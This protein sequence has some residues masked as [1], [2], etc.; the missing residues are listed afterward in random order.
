MSV[1]LVAM[2]FLA[3]V[4]ATAIVAGLVRVWSALRG[5]RRAAAG[6]WST[7]TP[8]LPVGGEPVGGERRRDPVPR[9]QLALRPR[10]AT[11]RVL[12]GRRSYLCSSLRH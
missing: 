11:R 5:R 9:H 12:H 7:S 4:A 10:S 3:M 1:V 8:R 2:P 6:H